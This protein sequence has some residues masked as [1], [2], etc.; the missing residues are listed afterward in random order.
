MFKSTK[1]LLFDSWI[2]L[3]H[4]PL[5]PLNFLASADSRAQYPYSKLTSCQSDK[6]DTLSSQH[7]GR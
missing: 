5:P 7:F 4:H 6:Q 3:L 2:M 1:A